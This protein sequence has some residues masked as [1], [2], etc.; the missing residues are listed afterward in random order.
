MDCGKP[1]CFLA[2]SKFY[3]NK[4]S[5]PQKKHHCD[6]VTFSSNCLIFLK[7][8]YRHKSDI[9]V[10][11]KRTGWD[12][13]HNP[14][15]TQFCTQKCMT[16][17]EIKFSILWLFCSKILGDENR[18]Y[19]DV[20]DRVFFLETLWKGFSVFWNFHF[21]QKLLNQFSKKYYQWEL[22]PPVCMPVQSLKLFFLLNPLSTAFEKVFGSNFW[23]IFLNL[24]AF[25]Q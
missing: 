1:P 23:P 11:I 20:W 6:I 25:A 13:L 10:S 19:E 5:D 2:N 7:K 21:S 12:C 3:Y 16:L 17:G 22:R 9:L 15:R 18:Y 14:I 8:N 4:S 24:L